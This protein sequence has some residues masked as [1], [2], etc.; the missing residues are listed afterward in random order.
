MPFQWF[1]SRELLT[2]R[3]ML[4]ALIMV[5]GL[6][7]IYG[8]M[9]YGQQLTE[10]AANKPIWMLP[11]VPD[12]PTASLFFTLSL[13]YMLIPYEPATAV[14]RAVRS[15]IEA[16]GVVTSIKYGIW[17]VAMIV[18]GDSLGSATDWQD[19]MLIVSHAG[20]AVEALL[21]VR[22]MSV[23]S[24]AIGAAAAW[25]LLN[26]T[27]DYRFDVFPWLPGPLYDYLTI[28]CVCTFTLTILSW[29]VS[30]AAIALRD[31]RRHNQK[32]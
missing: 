10:T 12:S 17:A 9:W 1:W 21:Y 4:W 7:T 5:N 8:Y 3:S 29:L 32:Y 24:V 6:G 14:G 20:M 2:S 23:G 15:I 27:V 31:Y 28:V 11:F 19:W 13:I 18:A 25:L 22:F 16:L 30:R 26:D